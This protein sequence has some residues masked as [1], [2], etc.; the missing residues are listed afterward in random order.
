[1]SGQDLLQDLFC[2]S[3][4]LRSSLFVGKQ[5][6][7]LKRCKLKVCGAVDMSGISREATTFLT[8][9]NVI[10]ERRNKICVFINQG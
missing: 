3:S 6:F 5:C 2:Y 1:M 9:V 8:A 7:Q 4:S 10:T